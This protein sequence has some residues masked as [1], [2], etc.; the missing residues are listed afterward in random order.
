[1]QSRWHV[2]AVPE[3]A[4]ET[5]REFLSA[6]SKGEQ[7]SR[8]TGES[9]RKTRFPESSK[10]TEIVTF[11]GYIIL[12]RRHGWRK[13]LSKRNIEEEDDRDMVR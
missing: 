6:S 9:W 11:F 1:M 7:V 5:S 2:V 12:I 4:R 3:N 10:K 13:T 8:Y